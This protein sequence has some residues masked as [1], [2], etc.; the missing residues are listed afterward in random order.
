MTA[1]TTCATAGSTELVVLLSEDGVPCGTAPK[2]SV[3]HSATPLHLA[4]SCWV[5][6]G[7]GRTL[8]TR[9]AEVKR[10][11][12][13]VWTNSFCGHPGPGEEPADAVHRRAADE[14]GTS[15]AGVEPVLPRFR[16]RAEMADGTVENEVCPVFTAHLAADLAPDPAEVG[17]WRWVD[18][19]ELRAEVQRDPSPFSPW[20]LLQLAQLPT[21]LG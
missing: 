11:W 2:A 3:H 14:L 16:Y 12:P 9:R 10:T 7:A 8:L 13:G 21:A 17:D 20:M 18:L 4:F 19:D 15:V 6:D 5:V 1:P